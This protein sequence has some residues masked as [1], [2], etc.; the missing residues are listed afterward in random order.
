MSETL[1]APGFHHLHLNS[2]DP[3][4]AIAFYVR[5]FPRSRQTS[6]GGL[7]ALAAPNDVLVLFTRVAA[8]PAT[9]PQTAIWHFGWHVTDTHKSLASYKGRPDVTLLPLYTTDEG[10]SVFVSS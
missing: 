7:P 4:A 8:A 10:G 3:E 5:Q 2:V 1:P 9:S 6:W